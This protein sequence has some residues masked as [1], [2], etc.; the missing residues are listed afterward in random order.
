MNTRK[1]LSSKPKTMLSAR[2][3]SGKKI[4]TDGFL[5]KKAKE[6]FWLGLLLGVPTIICLYS[7]PT[8]L[9]KRLP[10]NNRIHN[11]LYKTPLFY[12]IVYI[13]IFCIFAFSQ[14]PMHVI[15]P[16]HFT[17]MFSLSLD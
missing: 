6:V 7:I 1:T 11:L 10:F 16:F 2:V 9:N 5:R 3:V 8:E 13:P 15:L 12:S 17:A 4:M 14:T